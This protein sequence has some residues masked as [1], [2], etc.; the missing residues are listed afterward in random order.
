MN[1]DQ[2]FKYL[3]TEGYSHLTEIPGRG[4]CGVTRMIYTTGLVYGIDR[5]S[6]K[7]RYCFETMAVAV[8]SLNEWSGADD[9]PGDWIKHKGRIEYSNPNYQK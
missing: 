1:K 4:I 7:G 8:Q 9:P 5:Y 6:Y 3:E 2:L